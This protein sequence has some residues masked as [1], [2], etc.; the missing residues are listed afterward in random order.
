MVT[1][2]INKINKAIDNLSDNRFRPEFIAVDNIDIAIDC[3]RSCLLAKKKQNT[4]EWLLEDS[5]KC[6]VCYSSNDRITTYCPS[7]GR[8]MTI[9]IETKNK[10][11]GR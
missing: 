4:G 6:S 10:F 7:C 3:M 5:L 9:S 2:S 1:H 8:K 11:I